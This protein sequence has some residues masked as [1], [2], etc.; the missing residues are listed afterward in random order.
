MFYST[1]NQDSDC[2]KQDYKYTFIYI[3]Y[4]RLS[5]CSDG[6]TTH[7][8]CRRP[9]FNPCIRKIPWRR[10][11]LPTPVFLPGNSIERGAWWATAHGVAGLPRVGHN[12]GINTHTHT[13]THTHIY[14]H[15][16]TYTHTYTHVRESNKELDSNKLQTTEKTRCPHLHSNQ[17]L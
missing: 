12:W 8:Q 10:E 11:W 3:I 17:S 1:G 5:W 2:G 16:H 13:H 9:G 14:T 6:K 4:I 7:M 15:V